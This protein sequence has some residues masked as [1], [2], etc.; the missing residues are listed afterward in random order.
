MNVFIY[1]QIGDINT[2]FEKDKVE[3]NTI[4]YINSLTTI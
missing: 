3:I 4:D 1:I 2:P